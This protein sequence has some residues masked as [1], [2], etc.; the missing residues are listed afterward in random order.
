VTG[1]T[2][3]TLFEGLAD[4]TLPEWLSTDG[5][6]PPVYGPIAVT[7]REGIPGIIDSVTGNYITY[8]LATIGLLL[9]GTGWIGFRRRAASG[10]AG[11][12]VLLGIAASLP[13]LVR[14]VSGVI[15]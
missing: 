8:L 4:E 9:I 15:R 11:H 12:L 14:T 13:P 7:V 3:I 6:I 2:E 10:I 1:R 5:S